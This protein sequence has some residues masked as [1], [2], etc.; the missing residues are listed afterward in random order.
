MKRLWSIA[1]LLIVSTLAFALSC[2]AAVADKRMALVIGNSSYQNAAKL[3]NPI[4]DADAVA[5]MFR[6]VGYEVRLAKD[7]GYLQFSRELRSFQDATATADIAVVYYAGHGVEIGATNYMVPVDARLVRDRDAHDEAIDLD[8]FVETVESAKKLRLLILDACRD[9]PFAA[10]TKRRQQTAYRGISTGGLGPPNNVGG[11][12]LIAYAAKQGQTAEDGTGDHSPFTTAILHNLTVPGVDVRLAFGRVRDEVLNLTSKHQEPFVYGSLGGNQISLAPPPEKPDE[13]IA[14]QDD[15]VQQDFDIV[16]KAYDRNNRSDKTPLEIYLKQHPEGLLSN[17][18]RNEIVQFDLRMKG[19]EPSLPRGADDVLWADIKDTSDPDILRRYLLRYPNSPNAPAARARLNVLLNGV[20]KREEDDRRKKEEADAE[21]KR[22]QAE[23][24]AEAKR[25]AIAKVWAG[26]QN[27]NDQS[28]LRDFIRRYPESEY[29]ADAKQRLDALAREAQEREDK[30]RAAAAEDK[31]LKAE[32]E[33]KRAFDNA[34]ATTDQSEVRDFIKRYP[35]SAYVPQ[36]KQHLDTLVAAEE[37][38]KQQERLAAAE[39][40]RQKMEVEAAAAWNSIKNTTDPIELQKFIKRFPESTLALK[41][42]PER[43][44]HLDREAKDRV[45]KAQAEAASVRAEWEKIKDTD[46][47]AAV[48]KFIRQYPNTPTTVDAKR[49]L[50][51]LD[52]R[53]KEREARARMEA[54]AAQA[55]ERIKNTTD[56]GELRAFIKHYP[57]S[58]LALTDAPQRL[59][60]LEREA[61]ERA[62]RARAEAATAKMAWYNTKDTNDPA[63]L[64]DFVARYPN[65]SFANDAKLRIDLLERQAKERADRASKEAAERAAKERAEAELTQA[66]DQTKES[67]DPADFRSFIKRYPDSRFTPI[68]KQRLADLGPPETNEPPAIERRRESVP[69]RPIVSAPSHV[70][71]APPPR[72][73]PPAPPSRHEAPAPP[74]HREA[75]PH[76]EPP[77]PRHETAP[78]REIATTSRSRVD[79]GSTRY[80]GGGGGGYSGGGGFSGGGSSHASTMSGVGF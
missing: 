52:L 74:P 44:G 67:R 31:R 30:A 13:K 45:A 11:E 70:P 36:A 34:Q 24:E 47:I 2:V 17:L 76:R 41:D 20:W 19:D 23:A 6:K 25:Q 54:E 16:M 8:R 71:P 15:R 60:A 64:R 33:M 10:G 26:V 12:L 32:A 4:G 29:I 66:W 61:A 35:D 62:E 56:Q 39:A 18:I 1:A 5:E 27:S 21:A 65:S 42:A 53:A 40:K 43:L 58:A 73:V 72:Y 69:P 59:A 49:L 55:W 22:L 57:K 75:L 38:R 37:Q 7:L 9:N 28:R 63:E 79:S 50:E 51:V 3:P 80:H 14:L 48:Q 68:A 46:D 78:R 77:A